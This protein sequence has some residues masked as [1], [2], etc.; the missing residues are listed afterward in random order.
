MREFLAGHVPAAIA[1][2][3]RGDAIPLE[4]ETADAVLVSSAWHWMDVEPTLVE[5]G[6]VLRPGGTLG[7]VWSGADRRVPW[8]RRWSALGRQPDDVSA[9]IAAALPDAETTAGAGET[10]RGARDRHRFR[11]PA[12]A[13]FTEPEVADFQWSQMMTIDLLV[14]LAGTYST[15]ITL[16]P[17]KR[18]VVLGAARAWL[19]AEPDLAGGERNEIELAL[20]A[21][22]WR[23]TLAVRDT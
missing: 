8:I 1:L 5:I 23:T 22:C 13:P 20:R 11:L 17:A 21:L 19:E 2:A 15:V 12:G 14:G 18:E 9:G 7:V 6:R 3:G 16:P 10:A 4:G